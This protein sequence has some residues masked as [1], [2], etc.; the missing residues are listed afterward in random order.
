MHFVRAFIIVATLLAGQA[1][2]SALADSF[3]IKDVAGREVT[4]DKPVERVVLGQGL[5]IH[6]IAAIDK[7][8]PFA[9]IVAWRDDLWK[10]DKNKTWNRQLSVSEPW[11]ANRSSE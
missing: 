9:K 5:M 4:F 3:T 7:E 6:A 1:P 2:L 11:D 10:T 8:D